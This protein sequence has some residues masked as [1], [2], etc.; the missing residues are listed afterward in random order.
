MSTSEENAADERA[1]SEPGARGSASEA[2]RLLVCLDASDRAPHVL[3]AALE[4]AQER[5]A[6]LELFRV[7]VGAG[8]MAVSN[9]ELVARAKS[10]LERLAHDVPRSILA[11]VH[12]AVGT[13]VWSAI[14]HAARER[15][16]TLVVIG[17]HD[18][19]RIARALGT[20]AAD[21]VNHAPCSVLVVRTST[22]S[23][24]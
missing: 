5:G 9:A 18:H 24:A 19:G 21:V 7:I 17:K 6:R 4:L 12:A 15:S 20:T 14:C 22:R 8:E 23:P 1:R 10:N 3:R 2:E 16:A 13:V 11:G